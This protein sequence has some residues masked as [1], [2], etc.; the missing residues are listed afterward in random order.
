VICGTERGSRLLTW[1]QGAQIDWGVILLVGTGIALGKLL[2]STGLAKLAGGTLG[3]LLGYPSVIAITLLA[4]V[5]SIL[6]SELASNTASVAVVVPVLIPI[7]EAAGVNP[8]LP[9]IAAVFG[10]SFG[11]ML[12]IS[13]VPN[14]IVYGAGLV[15]IRRMV[16]TG[17]VFDVVGA[18]LLTAGV[19]V[20]SPVV[21]FDQS[22]SRGSCWRSAVDLVC[23]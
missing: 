17:I 5:L 14:A 13:Q 21:G 11:F 8:L 23:A 20:W 3:E 10:G 16:R 12:P 4:V 9:A 2:S 22:V 18:L 6:L 15:P 7:A 1:G 19:L